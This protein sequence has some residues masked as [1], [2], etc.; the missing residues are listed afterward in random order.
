MG[1]MI[2]GLGLGSG[3]GTTVWV[4]VWVWYGM[5]AGGVSTE[6]WDGCVGMGILR[7]LRLT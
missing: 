2:G 6:A 3:Y 4:W 5:G 1:W 7:P